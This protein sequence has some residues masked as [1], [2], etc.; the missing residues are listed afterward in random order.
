MCTAW[1]YVHALS[2]YTVPYMI[3]YY[4]YQYPAYVCILD[5]SCTLFIGELADPWRVLSLLYRF[6]AVKANKT[7][8]LRLR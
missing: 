1:L 7:D 2:Y 5:T 8:H 4:R 6:V 3:M